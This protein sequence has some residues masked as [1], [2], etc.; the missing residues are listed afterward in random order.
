MVASPDIK[1]IKSS[2]VSVLPRMNALVINRS[3]RRQEIIDELESRVASRGARMGEVVYYF[4]PEI[5]ELAQRIRE[6]HARRMRHGSEPPAVAG[7]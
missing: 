6:A 4:E 2:A 1:D 3:L 5:A 7:G